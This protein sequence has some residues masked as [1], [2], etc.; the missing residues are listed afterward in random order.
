MER[1][2]E[3]NRDYGSLGDRYGE[4]LELCFQGTHGRYD[5]ITTDMELNWYHSKVSFHSPKKTIAVS[6]P[7]LFGMA[8]VA[9]FGFGMNSGVLEITRL[10]LPSLSAIVFEDDSG[11]GDSNKLNRESLPHGYHG[12]RMTLWSLSI[13]S[14]FY[15]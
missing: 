9:G 4:N 1:W 10:G 7:T 6:S 14:L 11:R 15:S 2:Q 3:S 5:G 12:I 8:T 13:I